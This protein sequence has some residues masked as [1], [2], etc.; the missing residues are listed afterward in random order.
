VPRFQ[1]SYDPDRPGQVLSQE[2]E[3]VAMVVWT[4]D[5]GEREQTGWFLVMLDGDGEPDGEPPRR[6]DVSE[7]VDRLV[8]DGRLDRAAW[9]AQA[10]TLELVPAPAAVA[11]GERRLAELLDGTA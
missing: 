3:P 2:G 10:E 6:L 11:A 8:A 7:E 5:F 4:H 9:L 1:R